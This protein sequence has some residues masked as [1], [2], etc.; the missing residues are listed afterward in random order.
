MYALGMLSIWDIGIYER[1]ILPVATSF[2]GVMCKEIGQATGETAKVIS[3]YGIT[4]SLIMSIVPSVLIFV[5]K[6]ASMLEED[7]QANEEVKNEIKVENK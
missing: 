2:I 6:L 4:A 3:Q 1:Y 7:I 5:G